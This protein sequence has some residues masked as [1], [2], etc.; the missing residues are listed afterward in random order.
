MIS[1]CKY[2]IHP[3]NQFK[4]E[5]DNIIYYIKYKL[6]NPIIADKFYKDIINRISS[7]QF[8]PEKYAKIYDLKN[9][10]LRKLRVNKYIIVYYIDNHTRKS[11][12]STYFS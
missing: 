2:T 7:L 4:E 1:K 10:K 3:T 8:M 6:K 5:M 11:F 12:Y 9:R